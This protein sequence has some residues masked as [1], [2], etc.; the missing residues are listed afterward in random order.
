LNPVLPIGRQVAEPLMI[1]FGLD[2][3]QALSQAAEWLDRVKIPPPAGAWRTTRIT[4]RAAC[5]SAS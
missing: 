2:R 4:C 1:H 3:S 5:A